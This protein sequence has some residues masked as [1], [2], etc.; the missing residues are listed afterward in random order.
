MAAN[1]GPA[2]SPDELRTLKLAGMMYAKEQDEATAKALAN[3]TVPPPP[4]DVQAKTDEA[5][6]AM[7]KAC[8]KKRRRRRRAIYLLRTAAAVALIVCV[9][10]PLAFTVDA[11]RAAVA[12][13]LIQN[14]DQFSR[15][16]YD[17]ENNAKA[18]VGWTS[19]YYP[20]WLPEGYQFD[21]INYTGQAQEIWY[22]ND[23]GSNIYFSLSTHNSPFLF[24]TENTSCSTEIVG[25]YEAA[26]CIKHDKRSCAIAI[27][28][29][30]TTLFIQGPLTK[31]EILKIANST[32]NLF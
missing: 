19:E 24:D 3:E 20:Q 16:T 27:V 1:K 31:D 14:F 23:S 26:L 18:P 9:S 15:I 28:L 4:A 21:R 32:H 2:A 7:L 6:F 25:N 29:P 17:V 10:V 5:V 8:R 12:N 13:F 11:S 22:I 30:T